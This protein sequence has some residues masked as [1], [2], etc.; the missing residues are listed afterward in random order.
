MFSFIDRKKRL[1]VKR[2][3]ARICDC[4]SPNLAAPADDERAEN[5]YNRCIPTLI[6]PWEDGE[7]CVNECT[8]VL[9]KDF[10]ENG[11]G[12]VA[13]Q[14]IRADKVLVGVW[15]DERVANVPWFFLGDVRRNTPLGGGFWIVG[16]ALTEF[17]ND[18]YRDVLHDVMPLALRLRTPNAVC[19]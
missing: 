11:I 17:A 9:T 8:I 6:C 19:V 13:N 4:T 3:L 7:P 18:E 5:R 14:P 15:S 10:A 1:K 16:V 12:I 2:Y